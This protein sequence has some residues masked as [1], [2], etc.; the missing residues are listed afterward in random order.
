MNVAIEI[1]RTDSA[2]RTYLTWAPVQAKAR[3][4]GAGG[5][6]R[7]DVT[8][9]DSGAVGHVQLAAIRTHRGASSLLLSLPRSGAWVPFWIAGVFQSPSRNYG[10]A[11]IEAVDAGGAALGSRTMMIRVRKNAIDLDAGERARFLAALATLNGAGLGRFKD[12]RAMHAR[13]FDAEMHG[14]VGFLPWH[15]AYLLDLERELQA[16]DPSVALPYWRFNEPAPALFTDT[17]LGVSDSNGRVHF[18]A[19]HPLGNWTTDNVVGIIRKPDFD[20]NEAPWG[21][22]TEAD[23][24]KLGGT[25]G[26]YS[27]FIA[28]QGDPH[29]YAHTSF[30]GSSIYD[31]GTAAKDPLFFLLHANLDRLWAYWQWAYKRWDPANE[32]S[33]APAS[34]N[35]IG[36][37]LDDSMWPWNGITGGDRPTTA[38]GGPLAAS[39]LTSAPGPSPL[40]RQMLDYQGVANGPDLCFAYDDVPFD[41]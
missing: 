9:R 22:R 19:G 29:G 5:S 11:G 6:G 20:T 3:L 34:P 7:V 8:L 16:I 14:N 31:T 32:N 33:Y 25:G 35:R 17:Y 4:T 1:P 18:V 10:D 2:G 27:K 15:R 26:A 36:Q 23:T 41:I 37:R 30:P 28:M 21:L 40:V 13:L 24:I 39:P 12:V 38:P